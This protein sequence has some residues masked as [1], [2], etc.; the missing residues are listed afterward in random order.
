MKEKQ[1]HPAPHLFRSVQHDAVKAQT[2]YDSSIPHG[3]SKC[4]L[5]SRNRTDREL[6]DLDYSRSGSLLVIQA[7][8]AASGCSPARGCHSH[9]IVRVRDLRRR[10]TGEHCHPGTCLDLLLWRLLSAEWFVLSAANQRASWQQATTEKQKIGWS[11]ISV[12]PSR[13]FPTR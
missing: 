11:K 9:T 5:V 6:D 2:A 10:R 4:H 8:L 1:G 13:K 7:V 3:L 12:S